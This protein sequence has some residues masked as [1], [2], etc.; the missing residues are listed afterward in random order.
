MNERINESMHECSD[1]WWEINGRMDVWMDG[2]VDGLLNGWMNDMDEMD[3]VGGWVA[4]WNEVKW[5]EQ[6]MRD[7]NARTKE[8][9]NELTK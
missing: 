9:L 7:I 1:E 6:N 8:W 5:K 4:E 2:R 3:G